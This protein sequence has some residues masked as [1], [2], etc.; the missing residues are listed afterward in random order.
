MVHKKFH[1]EIERMREK[2]ERYKLKA[3][4]YRCERDELAL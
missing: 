3:E 4:Q 2:S 1:V